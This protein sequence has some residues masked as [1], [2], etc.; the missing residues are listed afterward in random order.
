MPH[1]PCM[2]ETL[3]FAEFHLLKEGWVRTIQHG[4]L[5]MMLVY[6]EIVLIAQYVWQIPTRLNC[7]WVSPLLREKMEQVLHM[8]SAKSTHLQL[9]L[10]L[11]PSLA[12]SSFHGV[13]WHKNVSDWKFSGQQTQRETQRKPLTPPPSPHT[14]KNGSSGLQIS[15]CCSRTTLL[16]FR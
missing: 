14:P 7:A 3:R 10:P 16:T 2:D 11:P 4:G 13:F 8:H 1:T 15:F 12:F 6:T 5:Q 9:P